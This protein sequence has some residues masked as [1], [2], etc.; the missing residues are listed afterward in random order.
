M[1]PAIDGQ[2]QPFGPGEWASGCR[3]AS[4]PDAATLP[5]DF[6]GYRLLS[7]LG[8]GGM[9]EVYEAEQIATGR[10]VALKMLGCGLDSPDMRQRF[11]RE[12]RLAA[13]VSHP[14]SLYVFG[15]E[16]IHGTPVITME[17]ADYGTLEDKLKQQGPLGVHEAVD[18]MLDVIAGLESALAGGVL[19]RD[20]KPSNCFVGPDGSVKVGDF[21]LSVST[22]ATD[23][24]YVTAPGVIMGTP[25]YAPPEQLRGDDLDV[26]ADIYSVG[27][28]LFALL[29]GRPP[30][31]GKNAVQVVANVMNQET[32]RLTTLCK[33]V[34]LGLERVL[35][36]C[37]AKAPEGRY[38]D[39]S[40]LRDALLRFSSAKPEPAWKER[41]SAGWIDYLI[42]FLI[43]YLV[44]MSFVSSDE[45]HLG[46][47]LE[48]SWYSARYH[49]TFLCLGVLYFGIA[50]GIWGAGFGKRLKGLRVIR[51]NGKPPGVG[52]AVTRILIQLLCIEII[53]LPLGMAIFSGVDADH[54][55]ATQVLLYIAAC[56]ACPWLCVLLN[57][58][59]R[60]ENGFATA[61]DLATGTRV[62]IMPQVTRRPHFRVFGS[63]R[64]PRRAAER[65]GP[66]RPVGELMPGD[67]V[68]ADDPVLRR[69]VWLLRRSG[70]EPS[71]A[72]R[73]VA[74]A[75]RL[76]WLQK[77][78]TE[79]VT[80]DAFEASKGVSFSTLISR[81]ETHSLGD[82]AS[83][84]A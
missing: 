1:P 72:R 37:L 44:L 29:T 48:R 58:T 42:A 6:G 59:A 34:P 14:N 60:P 7:L 51:T 78:E 38:A 81:R 19:H 3:R 28:T 75:S 76:R 15:S 32:P 84:V 10:R 13:R 49:L 2:T 31:E 74:R 25:A 21:G 79:E 62:V 12:G 35:N 39:Y 50:E 9:G 26:R 20:I 70:L 56:E 52:R 82:F 77:V 40:L 71:V 43:P 30:F 57:L 18:A 69:Q 54:I 46:M 67:W 65:L 24:S 45:F 4:S 63:A 36:R 16:E 41:P 73:N 68:V 17:V 8:S 5:C 53:R 64:P 80:W 83:L 61:W 27:A 11:L 55:S 33:D 66:Y 47:Y 22:L 23:D